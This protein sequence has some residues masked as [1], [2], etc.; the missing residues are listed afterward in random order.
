MASRPN[1]RD[2]LDIGIQR[3][4]EATARPADIAERVH[5]G[6]DSPARREATGQLRAS[7]Q[8]DLAP[9]Q[10]MGT[11][12]FRDGEIRVPIIE[13]ELVIE[14]RP[15]VKEELVIRTHT[16]TEERTI[17]ADVRKERV[18]VERTDGRAR[19]EG[20]TSGETLERH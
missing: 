3:R 2:E 10:S 16:V 15:V 18:D 5:D 11:P 4:S 7:M 12:V 8:Q 19:D 9:G 14:K 6:M 1:G 20:D 13:E 17:H